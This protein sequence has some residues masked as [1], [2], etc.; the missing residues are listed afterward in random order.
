MRFTLIH[1]R[2]LFGDYF[3]RDNLTGAHFGPCLEIV[4]PRDGVGY[5]FR[6]EAIEDR[7]LLN[8]A[9]AKDARQ[10]APGF[11]RSMRSYLQKDLAS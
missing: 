2:A 4:E 9:Y 3:I 1:P 10:I 11:H 7:D 8:A 6:T 5:I